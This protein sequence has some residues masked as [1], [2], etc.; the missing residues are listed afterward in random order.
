MRS[1]RPEYPLFDGA[2]EDGLD[3]WREVDDVLEDQRRS[4]RNFKESHMVLVRAGKRAFAMAE[5]DAPSGISELPSGHD[6][7][8]ACVSWTSFVQSRKY[9][10]FACP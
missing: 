1:Q 10:V 5:E 9:D 7:K 4:A 6:L 2:K 8:W 3:S